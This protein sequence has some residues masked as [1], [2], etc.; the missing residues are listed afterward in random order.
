MRSLAALAVVAL[1]GAPAYAERPRLERVPV[2]LDP[3]KV[4]AVVNSKT[5]FLNRCTGGCKVT[6]GFTD[7]RTNKSAIGQGTLSAYSYG[8]S[9][10]STVVTCMK[11]VFSRFNVTV[12]DVDP[13]PM[14]DHFEVMIAGTPGQLGLPSSVGGIAEY[15]CSAPGVCSKYI[16][17]ALVF[18]FSGVWGGNTNEICAAAAQELAHTWTLDHVVDSS[19]PMTYFP[20][21]GTRQFKDNVRCGSD[22][23]NAQSPFGLACTTGTGCPG[24]QPSCLHT[25]MSTGAATQNDIQILTA[26]FGPAGAVAPTLTVTNPAN[27]STQQPGFAITAECT[28]PAGKLIQ[29]VNLSIDGLPKASLTVPPFAFMAPANIAEGPHKVTVLCATNEQAITVVNADVVVGTA[30]NNGACAMPGYICF[31]GACIAGPE[32]PGGLGAAC[33]SNADCISGACAS[34]GTLMTCVIPCDQ[35]IDNCPSG[36]GCIDDGTGTGGGL[37]WVGADDG[38]GCCETS[39]GNG[40]GSMLLALGIAATLITRRRRRSI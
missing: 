17:N 3:A 11:S 39:P 38:S 20:F 14:V 30:C 6:T 2:K 23:V 19:D 33:S 34:D 7:S 4:P 24:S 16:P 22:C 36:F 40:L 25:C 35:A 21:S 8:N 31:N 32:A 28:P 13:G 18:A 9:S 29:E 37:C 26:L 12:T 10:W 27:G 15:S 5:I 1:F